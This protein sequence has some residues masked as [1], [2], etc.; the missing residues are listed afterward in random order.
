VVLADA[1][2]VSAAAGLATAP[3]VAA[4]NGQVSLVSLPANLLAAPAVAPATVLG[5]LAALL[6]PVSSPLAGVFVWLAGWPVRWLVVLAQHASAL[7][8]AVVGWP[9]GTTGALILTLLVLGGGWALWRFPR[10]RPVALA[11]LAGLVVLGWPIRQFT[12]GW[13]P[14]QAVVV[15]CD[16]GQ[17]DA[18][19]VP[20][21][22]GEGLLVDTG[23]DVGSVDRCLHRLG[24]DRLPM[25]LLSHLDADHAGG[26]AGA[27]AGREVDVVATGTLSPADARAGRV[28]RLARQ[29]GARR[30]VLRPGDR[31]AIG[32]AAL[33]VLAPPPEIA[34]AAAAANDLSVLARVT[35]RGVRVLFTGDLSA[36]AE[37]RI[38]DR[39][40]DVRADVLKVPHHG[41][42]DVDPEFL[43][44]TGA[45]VALISVGADNDYGHPTAHALR[46]LAQDGMQVHR[47]DREGDLA[48]AGVAGKWG[49]ASRGAGAVAAARDAGRAPHGAGAPDGV[50]TPAATRERRRGV[51][52]CRR[53]SS[54]SGTDLPAAGRGGRGGAAARPRGLRRARRGARAPPRRRGA[55]TGRRGAAARPAGRRAGA[56]AVR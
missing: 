11:A 1:L 3:L 16:V 10:A 17:G 25:V 15:A 5:L 36:E 24:I 35:V 14:A 33:E 34:T 41:S 52:P 53:G 28:D 49:V 55:R 7:P 6:A 43:A 13:P 50:A 39:G 9:A 4:L 37:A 20:T 38:L 45:R 48:V 26:L 23:P 44:A 12:G 22:P 8:D 18:L 46:L 30:V 54:T 47:T 31:Q 29:A 27:L 32:S 51:A 40:V 56:L 21:A 19:V 42:A 2:A